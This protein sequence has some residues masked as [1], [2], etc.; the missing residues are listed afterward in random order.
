MTAPTA[1]PVQFVCSGKSKHQ[2]RYPHVSFG[3][4]GSIG[5]KCSACGRDLQMRADKF[6][7]VLADLHAVGI[8][9][10]DISVLPY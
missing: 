2:R 6:L 8:T 5:F 3:A 4:N 9:E 10:V 1:T 7:P